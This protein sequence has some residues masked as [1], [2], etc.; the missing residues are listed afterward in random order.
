MTAKN[1]NFNDYKDFIIE[2]GTNY[3]KWNSGKLEC[4]M[5]R[6]EPFATYQNVTTQGLNAPTH[7]STW[8]F[9]H[10]FISP[11]TVIATGDLAGWNVDSI[12]NYGQTNTLVY[13]TLSTL[14]TNP[15]GKEVRLNAYAVG[16][17]K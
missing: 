13:I 2:Q 1:R 9:P 5:Y 14:D 10:A 17:W 11:P 12:G 15:V 8:T 4:W 7:R 3:T 16:R 6:T